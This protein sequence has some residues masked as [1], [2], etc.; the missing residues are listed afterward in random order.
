MHNYDIPVELMYLELTLG[1]FISIMIYERWQLMGGAAVVAGYLGIFIDRPLYIIV[2]LGLAILTYLIM[3]YVLSPR[4]F[5]YGR[6]RLVVMI[7]IGLTLQLLTGLIA[8]TTRQQAPWLVGLYGIGFVLPGLITQDIERQ[9]IA[10]TTITV[11][12]TSSITYILLHGFILIK[13]FLPAQFASQIL[14]PVNIRYSYDLQLLITAIVFS[15]IASGVLYQL[16]GIYS[17]GFVTGGYLSLFVLQPLHILFVLVMG[18]VVYL[19]VKYVLLRIIPIFGRT[20]F[21]MTIMT[22]LVFSLLAE[23]IILK[24]TNSGF[25]PFSG[26]SVIS[27]MI[28]GLVA[29]DSERQGVPKTFLGVTICTIIVFG[30]VKGVELLLNA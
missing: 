28:S 22:S 24:T 12:I 17:G 26:F 6:T 29:N 21:A 3:R 10:K 11:L 13:S 9:G 16:T 27:P 1:I 2:T 14:V 4:K 23:L 15:V 7:M 30:I 5:L 20:K 18:I 8:F 19:F 25:I